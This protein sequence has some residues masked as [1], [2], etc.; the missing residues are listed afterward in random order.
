[1]MLLKICKNNYMNLSFTTTESDFESEEE[2]ITT[3]DLQENS[4]CT[5]PN[6]YIQMEYCEK[7][8]LRIAIDEEQY[9]DQQRMWLIHREIVEKCAV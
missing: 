8:T 6:L 3:R 1:M 4:K 7:S 2:A 9:K 5:L